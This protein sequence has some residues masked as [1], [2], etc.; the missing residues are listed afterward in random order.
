M[1]FLESLDLVLKHF[2][3]FGLL[4]Q[5]FIVKFTPH[6]LHFSIHEKEHNLQTAL[7][8]V[9]N[10]KTIK[11]KSSWLTQDV[12]CKAIENYVIADFFHLLFG[13]LW[14]TVEG[15]HLTLSHYRGDNLSHL[16]LLLHFIKLQLEHHWES[17][18]QIETLGLAKPLVGLNWEP[19]IH[20]QN[21]NALGHS[22]TK[23]S[24]QTKISNKWC[25][26]ENVNSLSLTD[27]DLMLP[28]LYSQ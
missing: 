7:K 21:L 14:A 23:E 17:R 26:V 2:Q 24:V 4:A 8:C 11:Q 27:F 16:M 1:L 12:V 5:H 18:S 13:W 20:S 19:L 25:K 15:E 10:L 3:L 9:E 6:G 28:I 22:F